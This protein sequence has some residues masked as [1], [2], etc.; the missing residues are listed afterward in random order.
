MVGTALIGACAGC[1]VVNTA[2]ATRGAETTLAVLSCRNLC[3]NVV[4]VSIIIIASTLV[5]TLHL[6][7]IEEGVAGWALWVAA[8]QAWQFNK[9]VSSRVSTGL[10]TG[11]STGLVMPLTFPVRVVVVTE[12]R[13]DVWC[14]PGQAHTHITAGLGIGSHSSAETLTIT[15]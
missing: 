1:K 13:A 15:P 2:E 3:A 9:A 4:V 8:F 6:V 7:L 10:Q 5:H 14:S 12:K 11:G